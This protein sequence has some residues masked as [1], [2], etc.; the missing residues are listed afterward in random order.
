MPRRIAALC[1]L[2]LCL[3]AGCTRGL[4]P[5]ET[6]FATA[7]FGDEI[8]TGRVRVTQG[9][10][11][12][13]LVKTTVAA[14][15]RVDPVEG[16]CIR[17]PSPVRP[18]PRAFAL[19]DRVHFT[20]DLY[21]SDM[22]SGWP[23]GLRVPHGLIMAH[24]LVHVW[25]WQNRDRTGYRPWRA[26]AESLRFAD[27][28][29]YETE[30]FARMGYEQQAALVEDWLCFAVIDPDHPRKAE[31]EKILAPV[32]PLGRVEAALGLR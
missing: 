17:T 15:R 18:P 25:Q 13:P 7:M 28:Y 14:T 29:F 10:G 11:L 2:A 9:L 6:A 3:A 16:A 4:S 23:D 12:A 26:A 27:P 32:F 31:L 24:E 20:H 1:L 8:D 30:T 21:S 22:L 5:A 19:A